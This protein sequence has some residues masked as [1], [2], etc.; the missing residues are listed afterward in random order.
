MT[1]LEQPGKGYKVQ[2]GG[3]RDEGERGRKPSPKQKWRIP[4]ETRHLST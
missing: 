3:E 1:G 4:T 2:S